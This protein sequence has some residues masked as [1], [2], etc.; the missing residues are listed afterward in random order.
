MN[1]RDAAQKVATYFEEAPSMGALRHFL[2]EHFQVAKSILI[3]GGALR[4]L[5]LI[6]RKTPK[7][8]DVILDGI[9]A[10]NVYEMSGANRNFFGGITITF[11][12]FSVDIWRLE[13]TYHLKQFPL[14]CTVS[15]FLE[16]APL[17]LDKIAYDILTDQ[18]HDN[19][20]LEGIS[21]REIQYVPAWPYLE[22]IQAARAVLLHWK[23]DFSF[24]DSAEQLLE[25]AA[26][27]IE[28]DPTEVAN[29]RDYLRYTKKFFRQQLADRVI[30]ELRQFSKQVA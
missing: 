24:H 28:K 2:M 18:L 10:R 25:R 11:E 15:G 23:T 19:G 21:H 6:P 27:A 30:D 14:P 29:I 7:D 17:N 26:N 20:C 8:I 1:L 9:E 22:P 13:D 3:V 16:G 5:L 4:D 12:G